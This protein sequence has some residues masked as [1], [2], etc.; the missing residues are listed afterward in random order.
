M[1]STSLN[2]L[3]ILISNITVDCTVDINILFPNGLILYG[4][5]YNIFNLAIDEACTYI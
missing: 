4:G 1:P 5:Y 2:M 3:A